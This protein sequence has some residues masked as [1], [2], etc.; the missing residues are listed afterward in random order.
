M[1]RPVSFGFFVLAKSRGKQ[2]TANPPPGE[3]SVS[4]LVK[5]ES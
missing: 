5:E 3:T 2:T 4:F 1:A